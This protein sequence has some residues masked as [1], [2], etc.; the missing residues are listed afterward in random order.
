MNE[1]NRPPRILRQAPCEE[2]ALPPAPKAPAKPQQRLLPLLAPLLTAGMYLIVAQMRGS[3]GG[4]MVMIL[5]MIALSLTTVGIG[6]Y[7][8]WEQRRQY[9]AAEKAA[10]T[11]WT[12]ALAACDQHLHALW[13]Q[14]YRT[15]HTNDPSPQMLCDIAALPQS[16]LWERR[17]NDPDFLVVRIGLSD[18]PSQTHIKRGSGQYTAEQETQLA[19]LIKRYQLLSAVPYTLDML[20]L[21]SFGI[22]GNAIQRNE[23]L[24]ALVSQIIVHHSANDVRIAAFW[25]QQTDCYWDWL[26]LVPHTRPLNG[27]PDY[28]LLAHTD[29]DAHKDSVGAY[30]H[31]QHICEQLFQELQERHEHHDNQR[32]ALIILLPE[33]QPG[34]LIQP[35]MRLLLDRGCPGVA[36]VLVADYVQHLDGACKAY[37]DLQQQPELVGCSGVDGGQTFLLVDRFDVAPCAELARKLQRLQLA[38]LADG[39]DVPRCV[40]LLDLLEIAD[41][42]SYDPLPRWLQVPPATDEYPSGLHPV[43][44]GQYGPQIHHRTYLDLNEKSEGVHGMIA[45]TTGSGKSELL[46]TLIL[47]LALL[48]HPDRLNVLLIDFKGGAT[49]RELAPLPHTAGLVTDLAGNGAERALTAINSEL[50][51]RKTVLAEHGVPNIKR[52]RRLTAALALPNLLIAIDEFDEMARDYPAFIEELIRVAKQGRSLGVHLLFATQTPSNGAIKAGL[53]T[54]LTYWISLRVVDPEDSKLM[55]GSRAAAQI[56]NTTPGRAYKRVGSTVTV[57]QSA[58][59]TLPYLAADEHTDDA[60]LLLDS[61]GRTVSPQQRQALL[62]PA[63][64]AKQTL[65]AAEVLIDRL[66]AALPGGYAAERFRIWQPPLPEQLALETLLPATAP[67][68]LVLTLGLQ[69]EPEH[70]CQ[71]LI[72]YDLAQTGSLVVIGSSGTGKTTALRTCMVALNSI[73]RPDQVQWCVINTGGDAFGLASAHIANALQHQD[74][75]RIERLMAVLEQALA[76]RQ[77]IFQTLGVAH[78]SDYQQKHAA[79]TPLPA[80]VIVIDDSVAWAE[81]NPQVLPTFGRLLRTSR[82]YGIF[83]VMSTD[84]MSS[85]VFPA[86]VRHAIGQKI[87]LRLHSEADSLDLISKPWAA[88]ISADTPG[89]GFL[90]AMPRPREIQL[91]LSATAQTA[92]PAEWV[93]QQWDSATTLMPRLDILPEQIILDPADWAD[94]GADVPIATERRSLLPCSWDCTSAAHLLI[95]GSARHGVAHV[96]QTLLASLVWSHSPDQLDLYLLDY[97][98]CDLRDW[99]QLPHTAAYVDQ[100]WNSAAPWINQL[101]QTIEQSF[102]AVRQGRQPTQTIVVV[103]HGIE[104]LEPAELNQLA[105]WSRWA[106]Q[107]AQLDFH[108]LVTSTDLSGVASNALIKSLKQ[109][110]SCI[111]LG[112]QDVSPTQLGL[113]SKALRWPQSIPDVPQR[114]FFTVAGVEQFVQ[115]WALPPTILDDLAARWSTYIQAGDQTVEQ[116][117]AVA[118]K[119]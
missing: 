44:I 118:C 49:F 60:F 114:G 11:G 40:D 99:Q 3:R 113:S 28:R 30:A 86:D 77:E 43:P 110:R 87:V 20:A 63:A 81:H 38:T 13:Q 82:A 90:P 51:R 94:S 98:G 1:F 67:P 6:A 25:S 96:L 19:A 12:I 50:D 70:A 45:G 27:D 93:H 39:R 56:S 29:P 106:L 119:A 101:E 79:T 76:E 41:A 5:P 91:A 100:P 17:R 24:K 2:V 8:A 108:V 34:P 64:P 85:S 78:W 15:R 71:P 105:R 58:L 10:T 89:R 55:I 46:T 84:R 42:G 88:R 61:L 62:A 16:R 37:L 116:Q 103:I 36:I 104:L 18:A 65:S 4:G 115:F 52:Y 69:D 83:W 7:T 59:A 31:T 72:N 48:H 102:Q 92:L 66:Q 73:Y 109:E 35:L 97:R 80:W 107:G 22:V 68:G 57:F 112:D 23:V 111:V 9:R 32:P 54:N 95:C 117:G 33:P 21:K 74:C 47:A 75:E 14:Q 53:K 26:R